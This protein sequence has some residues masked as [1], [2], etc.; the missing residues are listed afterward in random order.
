MRTLVSTVGVIVSICLAGAP[1]AAEEAK[2]S[3]GRSILST[4]S[5]WRMRL[6]WETEEVLLPSGKVDH[7][8]QDVAARE[9]PPCQQPGDKDAQGQAAS[10]R[11]QC[12]L[13]A[14]DDGLDLGRG[15]G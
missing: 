5:M 3:A 14:Q 13:E 10:H 12:D 4:D 7:A 15:R 1:L 6:L 2:R 9:V 11:P 8:V